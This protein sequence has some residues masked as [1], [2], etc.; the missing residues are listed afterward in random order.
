MPLRPELP[1]LP[2][3]MKYLP[4]DDR[5]YPVPWFVAMVDGKP[6]FRVADSQKLVRAVKESLCWVCGN[7][8]GPHFTFVIGP[9][10][11]VNRNTAEPPCHRVC[12]EFSA[13][14]CPFLSK[15]HMVRR[16]NDLPA[17]APSAG[18]AIRR[19][20]GVTCLWSCRAFK[21]FANNGGALFKL[22]EPFRVDWYAE[23]RPATREEVLAS[24]NS[25]LPILREIALKDGDEA[26]LDRMTADAM[27]FL[28]K[29]VSA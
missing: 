9:M 18:I 15:P 24:I 12:A 16:E 20:P 4:I 6:E 3:L 27:R 1:P 19:N 22:H 28:P 8:V 23:G 5:G 13:M 17:M 7:H 29:A 26:E 10:C 21:P 11:A 25:G 14:A 2:P